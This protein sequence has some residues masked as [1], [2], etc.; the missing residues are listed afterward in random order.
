MASEQ[1]EKGKEGE[2]VTDLIIRS[3]VGTSIMVS[4]VGF[5]P[6][7]VSNVIFDMPEK[8]V[9]GVWA[10][11]IIMMAESRTMPPKSTCWLGKIYMSG[12]LGIVGSCY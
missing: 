1:A 2:T 4:D 12:C 7:N 6:Q 9:G 8:Q 5:L 11:V 3:T 10:D